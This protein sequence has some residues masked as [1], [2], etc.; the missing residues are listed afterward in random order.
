MRCPQLSITNSSA[1]G[2]WQMGQS[3]AA[4][5]PPEEGAAPRK[6]VPPDAC[7]TAII[8]GSKI[9][10]KKLTPQ[11]LLHITFSPSAHSKK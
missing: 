3:S 10:K 7:T 11:N 6:D 9:G 2:S 4:L 1:R 5:L 8:L